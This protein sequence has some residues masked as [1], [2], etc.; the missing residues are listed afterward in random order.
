MDDDKLMEYK[1]GQLIDLNVNLTVFCNLIGSKISCDY[2][3]IQKVGNVQL[4][5][6]Y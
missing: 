4:R 1:K 6:Y 2:D 5:I 3:M